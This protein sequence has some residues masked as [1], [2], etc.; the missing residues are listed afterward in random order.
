M[1]G[2]GANRLAGDQRYTIER[3]RSERFPLELAAHYQCVMRKAASESGDGVTVNISSTGVLFT[4]DQNLQNGR[5]IELSI[6]W[7]AK[8]DQKVP[9]KLIVLGRI[10]RTE[11]GRAAVDILQ[12]EFRIHNAGARPRS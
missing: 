12:H 1:L 3:R 9:L 5:R 6:N 11:P 4:S 7:P 8:L 2:R 10:V